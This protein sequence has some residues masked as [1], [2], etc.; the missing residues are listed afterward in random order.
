MGGARTQKKQGG[1]LQKEIFAFSVKEEE[2]VMFGKNMAV[3]LEAGLPV[4][5]ALEVMMDQA[6]GKLK[7]IIERLYTRVSAGQAFAE[8]LRLEG[9]TFSNVFIS[10]VQ[11]GEMSGALEQ[12]LVHAANQMERDHEVRRNIRSAMMY[13]LI[14][15]IATAGLGFAIAIFVLPRMVEVF[16]SLRAELPWSTQAVIWLAEFSQNYGIYAYPVLVVVVFLL[17]TLARQDFARAFMHP[18]YL[19]LPVAS[20]FIHNV[21]RARFCRSLGTLLES[22]VPIQEALKTTS[23]TVS[24]ILYHRSVVDLYSKIE[25]GDKFSEIIGDY[26]ELYPKLVQ[27]MIG[28]GEHSGGMGQML[29]YL[30]EYFEQRVDSQSKNFSTLLEPLLLLVIGL[31]VAFVAIAILSPIYSITSSIQ[32]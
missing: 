25:T 11:I 18:L 5:E 30:A 31:V 15:L 8:A 22:G 27:R 24:N 26:P 17:I 13:P 4:V 19:R 12:S 6:T 10:A 28:V 3:M 2:L 1:L 20:P 23:L 21:N 14:V 16:T 7:E 29:L 32:I 9:K